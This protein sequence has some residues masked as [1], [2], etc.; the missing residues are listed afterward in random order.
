MFAE[1][2]ILKFTNE[3]ELT[4]K[5]REIVNNLLDFHDPHPHHFMLAY[6][7]QTA[8]IADLILYSHS[9][10]QLP[11]QIVNVDTVPHVIDGD[12]V[13]I[14]ELPTELPK[15]AVCIATFHDDFYDSILTSIMFANLSNRQYHIAICDG[16]LDIEQILE[17]FLDVRFENY[18][19]FDL[20]VLHIDRHADS[21][22]FYRMPMLNRNAST[23]EIIDAKDAKFRAPHVLF[24]RLFH[25]DSLDCHGEQLFVRSQLDPPKLFL[26][27]EP[28]GAGKAMVSGSQVYLT[29][30]MSDYLNA[31]FEFQVLKESR[32]ISR[33]STEYY[34]RFRENVYDVPYLD[35]RAPVVLTPY[36]YVSNVHRFS[37]FLLEFS[38]K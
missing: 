1:G 13:Y 23:V 36:Q 31:T 22:Q 25:D 17:L 33:G 38:S 20:A 4:T 35:G 6:Q 30:I 34:E 37:R 28:D 26:T 12:D 27:R 15:S 19:L 10:S 21:T 16:P 24:E 8:D 29:R 14:D 7:Q 5:L 11:W 32:T 9:G 3:H 2:N 18:G